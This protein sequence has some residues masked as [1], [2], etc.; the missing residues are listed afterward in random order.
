MINKLLQ[1]LNFSDKEI[2]VFLTI[3]ESGKLSANDISRITKINRT[4]IYSVTKELIKKVS[5]N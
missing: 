4:T 2:S 1:N 3:Q 5:E